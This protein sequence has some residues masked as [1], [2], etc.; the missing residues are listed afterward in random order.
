[1]GLFRNIINALT[2]SNTNSQTVDNTEDILNITHS[3]TDTFDSM[4]MDELYFNN[5]QQQHYNHSEDLDMD[6]HHG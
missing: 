6:I 2:S 5:V 1:M 3:S 4:P